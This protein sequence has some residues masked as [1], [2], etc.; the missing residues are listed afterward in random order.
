M[1]IHTSANALELW[2]PLPKVIWDS[3]P[4]LRIEA[5]VIWDGTRSLNLDQIGLEFS[6][7]SQT[8]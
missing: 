3:D 1:R 2:L 6:L 4:D 8:M 5:K 7:W